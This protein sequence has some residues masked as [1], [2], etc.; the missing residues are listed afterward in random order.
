MPGQKREDGDQ[1]E[2]T[3]KDMDDIDID[4]ESMMLSPE[5]MNEIKR[6][7]N[8]LNI[9]ISAVAAAVRSAEMK[10]KSYLNHQSEN[11]N[12]NKKNINFSKNVSPESQELQQ[13]IPK[14]PN[15]ITLQKPQNLGN[16]KISDMTSEIQETQQTQQNSPYA[17]LITP[18]GSPEKKTGN[19]K[20]QS[21]KNTPKSSKKTE[22][23]KRTSL[24]QKRM[25]K[26]NKFKTEK[27]NRLSALINE[28]P[29]PAKDNK[30]TRISH[31]NQ[32]VQ[33]LNEMLM[34][35]AMNE[36]TNENQKNKKDDSDDSVQ[37]GR[38]DTVSIKT[39]S[40]YDI[41]YDE[42]NN[43]NNNSNNNDNNSYVMFDMS[44][45]MCVCVCAC[46]CV[47]VIPQCFTVFVF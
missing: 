11:K 34:E 44:E 20:S 18:P 45:C 47:C 4:F 16:I 35:D 3:A 30:K 13:E 33:G 46:V 28:G 23:K 24:E 31:S 41:M 14:S 37:G 15:S 40:E 32:S 25:S 22:A 21:D 6:K 7:S 26:N 5:M 42:N 29:Q 8:A 19:N 43:N 38:D 39:D 27:E 10:R 2:E 1:G 36:N 9:P 17:M 12:N